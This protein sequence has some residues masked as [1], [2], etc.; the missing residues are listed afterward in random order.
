MINDPRDIALIRV[1][2]D[3]GLFLTARPFHEAAERLGWSVEEALERSAALLERGVIRRF[4]AALTPR[5]AG[6]RH[7][8]M[9]VWDID[10]KKAEEAGSALSGHPRVSHCYIRPRFEGFPFNIYTMVHGNSR[11]DLEGVTAELAERAGASR[12]KALH[13]VR[14]FKKSSPVYF[15]DYRVEPAGS[16]KA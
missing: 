6:F 3:E 15:M 9:V 12:Q 16:S 11:E 1:L 8:A 5:N 2:Q 14:E 13:T 4:G 10:D 7:N